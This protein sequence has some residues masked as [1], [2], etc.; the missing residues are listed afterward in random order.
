MDGHQYTNPTP[1][2]NTL[3]AGALPNVPFN[4]NSMY[5]LPPGSF[6]TVSGQ[7]D[8]SGQGNTGLAPGG[9]PSGMGLNLGGGPGN[10]QI[11]HTMFNGSVNPLGA[12]DLND[13]GIGNVTNRLSNAVTGQNLNP[14]LSTVR[15]RCKCVHPGCGK[16]FAWPQDLSKHVRKVH[17]DEPPKFCCDYENCGK[18]FYERKLLTAHTRTHTDERPFICP[19]IGCD[20][21]FR[22]RNALAYHVKALHEITETFSCTEHGCS[23]VTKRKDALV[24]HRLRHRRRV[25]TQEWKATRN[26]TV[27]QAVADAKT[28]LK[29]TTTELNSLS[30]QL[31]KEKKEFAKEQKKLEMVREKVEKLTRKVESND[32]A[33][34]KIADRKRKGKDSSEPGA[35]RVKIASE[36]LGTG[37]GAVD[38]GENLASENDVENDG[39]NNEDSGSDSASVSALGTDSDSDSG[40]TQLCAVIL[41]EDDDAPILS[42]D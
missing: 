19:H 29:D 37:G 10:G 30:K 28:E 20:K 39:N 13:Q 22:A 42:K 9:L 18:K 38:S 25:V 6:G 3:G 7:Y 31:Q 36:Q 32:A 1:N 15:E 26:E 33:L 2:P 21:A 27:K 12:S 34:R 5:S 17:E 16:E 24:T 23:F 35:R 40:D 4:G 41:P 8:I 14:S 11:P